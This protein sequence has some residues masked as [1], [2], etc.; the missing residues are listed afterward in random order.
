[1][2]E[3]TFVPWWDQDEELKKLAE[4]CDEPFT[5][6]GHTRPLCYCQDE[7]AIEEVYHICPAHPP[8]SLTHMRA[9]VK[10]Q[11]KEAYDRGKRDA[12]EKI[13]EKIKEVWNS[14]E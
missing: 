9:I 13:E 12:L 6:G 2:S 8:E 11:T 7:G 4:K 5:Y 10:W 3:K 1:M 14:E